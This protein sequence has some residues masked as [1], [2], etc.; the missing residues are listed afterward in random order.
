MDHDDQEEHDRKLSGDYS[1][2]LVHEIKAGG[3]G[4]AAGTRHAQHD[5][6]RRATEGTDS[7]GDYG[8]DEAHDL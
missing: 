5:L 2:D 7:D 1:Y 3:A 4:A 8:Y 6:N